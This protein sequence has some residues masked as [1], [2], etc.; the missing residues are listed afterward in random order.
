M[1]SSWTKEKLQKQVSL[2]L[3]D[4]MIDADRATCALRGAMFASQAASFTTSSVDAVLQHASEQL[5]QCILEL[6][7]TRE[8]VEGTFANLV[9]QHASPQILNVKHELWSVLRAVLSLQDLMSEEEEEE[10]A[11]LEISLGA[12]DVTEVLPLHDGRIGFVGEAFWAEGLCRGHLAAAFTHVQ[13]VLPL[14]ARA[15]MLRRMA[16][17]GRL[18]R[19]LDAVAAA[20][21]PMLALS[22]TDIRAW[23]GAANR[24]CKVRVAAMFVALRDSPLLAPHVA[25]AEALMTAIA[26]QFALAELYDGAQMDLIQTGQA[27]QASQAALLGPVMAANPPNLP[28]LPNLPRPRS[29]APSVASV[30]GAL[31]GGAGIARAASVASVAGSIGGVGGVGGVG[32]SGGSGSVGGSHSDMSIVAIDLQLYVSVLEAICKGMA[33]ASAKRQHA[34][35]PLSEVYTLLVESSAH[36]QKA[37]RPSVIQTIRFVAQKAI[38]KA[39]QR[40]DLAADAPLPA[41]R[42]RS[43]GHG[44]SIAADSVAGLARAEAV[45]R[46]MLEEMRSETDYSSTYWH[47]SRFAKNRASKRAREMAKNAPPIGVARPPDEQ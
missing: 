28:N 34:F 35:V 1:V 15:L 8:S 36:F 5:A 27:S 37:S 26:P 3:V 46:G 47:A 42:P 31:G 43:N 19:A 10:G 25:T 44:A 16:A 32:G 13:P 40:E 23:G 4:L 41:L 33:A 39:A 7:A 6:P 45:F 2:S 14:G 12:F 11:S 22:E 29:P 20:T 9:E 21:R 17:G 30:S 24:T 18:G 38:S